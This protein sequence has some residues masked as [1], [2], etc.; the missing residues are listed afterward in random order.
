MEGLDKRL[1]PNQGNSDQGALTFPNERVSAFLQKK[2]K[3]IW[4]ESAFKRFQSFE[5][6]GYQVS[7]WPR[8]VIVD[9]FVFF[10]TD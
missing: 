2:K 9:V 1:M 10:F 5:Q 4:L 7:I 6:I 3:K 8:R